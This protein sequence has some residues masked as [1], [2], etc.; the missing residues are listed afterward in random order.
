MQTLLH[1]FTNQLQDAY[2]GETQLV[3]ALPAMAEAASSEELKSIFQEHLEETK[4]QIKRLEEVAQR[5]SVS[6]EGNTCEAMQGLIQEGQEMIALEAEPHVKDAGLVAAAQKVEHYEMATYGCLC[7][8]AEEL[9][10]AD[11]QHILHD[12]LEEEKRADARLTQL[13]EDR[14]NTLAR[15]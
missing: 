7:T 14:I 13:A 8:W 6:V 12:T 9:D 1:L 11:V 15:R 2:S 10:L 3:K 5:I 4:N